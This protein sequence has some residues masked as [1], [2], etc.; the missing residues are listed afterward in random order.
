ML[1]D[2]NQVFERFIAAFMHKHIPPVF[3]NVVV[4]PQAKHRKT[5]L[6]QHGSKGRLIL[7]PDIL[8]EQHNKPA[9]II[10]TKWKAL[11][12][13]TKTGRGGTS[14]EDLY[15]MHA[16]S[17]RFGVAHSTLL[18]PWVPGEHSREFDVINES[19]TASNKTISIRYV[20]VSRPLNKPGLEL[21]KQELSTLVAE[22]L[23]R[24]PAVLPIGVADVG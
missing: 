7:K 11:T 19:G 18:Y 23:P 3:E 4:I 20:N 22:L 9:L 15:Q 2:M 16:Y 24:L 21:L 5:H 17:Q 8:I 12:T 6:L 10:D 13:G 1:F 14:R